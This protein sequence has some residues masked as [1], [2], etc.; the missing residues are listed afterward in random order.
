[1]KKFFKLAAIAAVAMITVVACKNNKPTEEPVDSTAIETVVE[2][3]MIDTLV[4]IADT[5]PVVEEQAAPTVKKVAQKV[6]ETK[7]E[8]DATV[9]D[10][11][12]K[13]VAPDPTAKA[14]NT[15]EVKVDNTVKRTRR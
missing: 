12:M 11:T 1:M 15:N 5:T 3:E 9:K 6:K 7:A 13:A 8:V 2:E 14:T 4:A 10:P